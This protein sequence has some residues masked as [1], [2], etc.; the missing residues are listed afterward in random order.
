MAKKCFYLPSP[1]DVEDK[2]KAQCLNGAVT[3]TGSGLRL[4]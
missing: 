3:E 4:I 2:I 1:S